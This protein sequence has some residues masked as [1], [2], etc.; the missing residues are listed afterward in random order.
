MQK[1]YHYFSENRKL[2]D[3]RNYEK[4]SHSLCKGGKTHV[5]GNIFTDKFILHID[6]KKKFIYQNK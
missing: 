4:R 6:N 1:S 2:K 5:H 3:E